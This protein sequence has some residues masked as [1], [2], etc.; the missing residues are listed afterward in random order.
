MDFPGITVLQYA[1]DGQWS[2]EEDYWAEKLATAQYQA[3]A[4]ALAAHDPHHREKRTR[5]DWGQG[6]A[7]T[8]GRASYWD[9]PDRSRA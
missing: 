5:T 6:P 9:W 7:W 3:Y 4:E 8:R 1:G 2:V